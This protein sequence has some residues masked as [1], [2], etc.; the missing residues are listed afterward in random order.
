MNY[1][2]NFNIIFLFEIIYH[3]N[4]KTNISPSYI[5]QNDLKISIKDT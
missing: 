3:M 5:Y 2:H 1:L 4:V